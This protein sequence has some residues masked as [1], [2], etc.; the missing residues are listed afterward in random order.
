MSRFGNF[1]LN[2]KWIR[3]VIRWSKSVVLPGFK[4][5]RL[6]DVMAVFF[7]NVQKA[8]INDRAGSISFF[9]L[10]ALP[11]T[12][13]FLFTLLPYIPLENLEN[14]IYLFV[15]DITPNEKTYTLLHG[16]IYDFLHTQRTG[17][18][19]FSFLLA[20]FYSST[21]VTGILRSFNRDHPG[22]TRRNM[23]KQRWMG[24]KLNCILILLLVM[25]VILMVAQSAFFNNLL[26]SFHFSH[27]LTRFFIKMVRWLIILF[28]F[29]IIIS[30]LYTYGP[31]TEKK[32]KFI[33]AGSTLATALTILSTLGFSYY[34]N[35]FSSYNRI[36]GSIGSLIVLMIW[37]FINSYVLLIGFELNTSIEILELQNGPDVPVHEG[38]PQGSS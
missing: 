36:Y 35:H 7:K 10:L 31:S 2:L 11:P 37:I 30:I 34:V 20:I 28:F 32:R 25:A 22:F 4:G 3:A 15:R 27:D 9:F 24:I 18:L 29:F 8:Q 17:L 1:L 13:I 26:I 33:T 21:A 38:K 12:C 16:I 23:V 5:F 14:T 6:Y 19:S